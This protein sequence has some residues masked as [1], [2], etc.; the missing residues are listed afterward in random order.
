[1]MQGCTDRVSKSIREQALGSFKDSD[2]CFFDQYKPVTM[3][4]SIL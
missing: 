1:M 3:F 4:L 2:F